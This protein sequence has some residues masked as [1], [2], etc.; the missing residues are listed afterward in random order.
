[1]ITATLDRPIALDGRGGG[2][3]AAELLAAINDA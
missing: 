2:N 3:I 1:M